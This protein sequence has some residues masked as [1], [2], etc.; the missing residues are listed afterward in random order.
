MAP[1]FILEHT[2]TNGVNGITPTER[3]QFAQTSYPVTVNTALV[4]EVRG[5]LD[6]RWYDIRTPRGTNVCIT[7]DRRRHVRDPRVT[8]VFP[9]IN[10]GGRWRNMRPISRRCFVNAAQRRARVLIRCSQ[11]KGQRVAIQRHASRNV[12]VAK[13]RS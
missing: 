6:C 11:R 13:L 2:R 7:M 4:R 12:R 10:I 1:V 5:R 3:V 9:A 8:S